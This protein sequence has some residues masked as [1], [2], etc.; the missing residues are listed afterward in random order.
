[1]SKLDTYKKDFDKLASLGNDLY[2]KLILEA[3]PS[4]LSEFK[5]QNPKAIEKIQNEVPHFSGRYQE[6]C[7]ESYELIR[8]L[9]PSRLADSEEYYKGNGKPRKILRTRTTQLRMHLMVCR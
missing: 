8:R 6:W 4:S 5:Q 9:L 1:V 7:S 2:L 3:K